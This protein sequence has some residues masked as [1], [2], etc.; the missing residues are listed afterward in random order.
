MENKKKSYIFAEFKNKKKK[1]KEKRDMKK[2]LTVMGIL[3][4]VAVCMLSGC[5]KKTELNPRELDSE[6]D[7]ALIEAIENAGGNV[8]FPQGSTAVKSRDGMIEITLPEG[9]FYVVTGDSEKSWRTTP[10]IGI[11]CTCTCDKGCNPVQFNNKFA[12]VMEETCSKCESILKY[13][14]AN[15][16]LIDVE[17]L[18]MIN[19]NAGITLL[20]DKPLPEDNDM[21]V[22]GIKGGIKNLDI[23]HGNAFETLFEI[24]EVRQYLEET[25]AFFEESQVKP[26]IMAYMN[27]LG[28]VALVPFYLP[29]NGK[30]FGT[31]KDGEWDNY[32][33]MSEP[34]ESVP[35]KVECSCQSGP[36]GCELKQTWTPVGTVYYCMAGDCSSCSMISIK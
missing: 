17:L 29:E 18:G 21:I 34:L 4:V 13:A 20:T 15:R 22:N 19:Q 35:G 5:S 33:A 14:D 24:D 31:E 28:N 32:Y 25:A 16:S 3:L 10:V 8:P 26:N 6:K 9:Y 7:A 1:K 27:L 12:C 30:V 2:K 11:I 23:I 36:S